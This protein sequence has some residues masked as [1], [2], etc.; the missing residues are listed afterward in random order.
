M[1]QTQTAPAATAAKAEKKVKIK[2]LRDCIVGTV[3]NE[4]GSIKKLGDVKLPGTIC[5][6][7]EW[8]AKMLCDT[9]FLGHHPFY[10]TMPEIGPLMGVDDNGKPL[11]NPLARK[12]IRRAIRVA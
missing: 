12:Q 5:E 10:G 2:I 7:P 9:V 8:E 1:D 11:P 4:D 3:L 6:A